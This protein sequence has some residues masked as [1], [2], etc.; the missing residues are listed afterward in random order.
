M[1]NSRPN[2][3]A[4]ATPRGSESANSRSFRETVDRRTSIISL[5]VFRRNT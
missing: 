5:R 4:V 3:A 1:D 2:G